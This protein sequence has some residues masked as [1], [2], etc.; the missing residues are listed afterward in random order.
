MKT[1]FR[2]ALAAL[3]VIMAASCGNSSSKG[4]QQAANAVEDVAPTVS[5]EQVSVREVPQLSTY[6][7]TV[8][9]YVKNNIAPQMAGR[10]TKINVEIGDF[11]TKGQ[12][13]AEMDKTSLLQA[14]L[15]LQNQEVELQ[16]L[17]AL[18]EA[19]GI[20]KSDY[21]AVELACN[22]AKSQVANLEENTILR[23]PVNGVVTA[24]NYDAGDMYAMS[25]P[26]YTVEQIKP[27]KLL[28]GISESEYTKVKKGDSVEIT[29]DALPGKTFY[30][31]IGKIYPTI[32]PATRTFTSEVVVDNNYNTLRPGMFARVTVDF[33]SNN[34]VVIPDV[35]VIKQQGS[36]ER[37][38]YV[39]NEDGTVTYQKIVLGRRMGTEYEVLEGLSDGAN[40]VTGGM[41]RLKDGI[42]VTVNE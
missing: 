24:R 36:G 12:V 9:A 6:T 2:S 27:V 34:N 42:K 23:S 26:I 14:Q 13:L 38:V 17:K 15:Q 16:R 11:V 4:P 22:V 29:A 32:D 18:Y 19:G 30:G 35:A 1:I 33:G 31:K 3:A 7:S 5:V 20:S 37:F 40:I 39:L 25:A 10:I 21:E 28:V 41:I 8:Q